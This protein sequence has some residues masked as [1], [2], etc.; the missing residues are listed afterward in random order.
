MVAVLLLDAGR[1]V[2]LVVLVDLLCFVFPPQSVLYVLFFYVFQLYSLIT[3]F[4]FSVVLLSLLA[5]F[6]LLLSISEQVDVHRFRCLSA[7]SV[8][9]GGDDERAFLLLGVALS[10]CLFISL[11]GLDSPWL[12]VQLSLLYL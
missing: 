1:A 8:A 10:L 11:M 5:F 2:P 4:S 3:V 7:E 6:F 9:D 12:V